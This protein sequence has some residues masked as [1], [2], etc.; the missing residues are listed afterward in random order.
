MEQTLFKIN[1]GRKVIQ[2]PDSKD[3]KN[4]INVPGDRQQRCMSAR[5]FLGRYI[6]LICMPGSRS[7]EVRANTILCG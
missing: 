5:L 7:K 1:G 4:E 3:I 6:K 2:L